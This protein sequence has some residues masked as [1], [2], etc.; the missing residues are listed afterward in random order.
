MEDD[1][2]I[3]PEMLRVIQVCK[4][5]WVIAENVGGLLTIDD[6]MVFEQV[7][8]DLE[9]SGYEVQP[10]IIPACAVNAWHRRYRVWIIANSGRIGQEKC[11]EQT[12]GIKQYNKRNG[13]YSISVNGDNG[14]FCSSEISQQQAPEIQK[15]IHSNTMPNRLQRGWKESDSQGQIGLYCGENGEWNKN[16]TEAATRLCG[17][18]D[19]VPGRIHR[20][21]A[22]GNSVVPEIVRIIGKYIMEVN[23]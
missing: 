3:W 4:P 11:E 10:F 21:K 18:A 1:R 20:L 8:V 22:L 5:T 2:A 19:G 14:G 13:G 15:I 12:A 17:M 23:K 16:W 6:G 9:T 7:C